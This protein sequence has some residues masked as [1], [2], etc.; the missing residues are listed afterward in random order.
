MNAAP[1]RKTGCGVSLRPENEGDAEFLLRLYLSVR[2]HE[3]QQVNWPDEAKYNFLA[4][5]FRI[6]TQQYGFHYPGMARWIVAS[7][8]G[9]IGRLY[10]FTTE[11]EMRVVDISLLPEWRGCGIGTALLEQ[12]QR[13]AELVGKPLRLQVEQYNPALHLYYR[14]GFYVMDKSS[15]YWLLEWQPNCPLAI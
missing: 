7:E 14:L 4:D 6:Q 5:Q 12:V 15:L 3:L 8:A 10:L 13:Q 2:W 1:L 11:K 9:S